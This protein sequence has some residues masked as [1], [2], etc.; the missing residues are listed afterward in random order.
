MISNSSNLLKIFTIIITQFRL[1]ILSSVQKFY[2][3]LKIYIH[4][5]LIVQILTKKPYKDPGLL[6]FKYD[7]KT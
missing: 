2:S 6:Y 3:I 5:I 7:F 4:I 1:F